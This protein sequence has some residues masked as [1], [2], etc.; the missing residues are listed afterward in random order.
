MEL[1]R[2]TKAES[3]HSSSSQEG[4]DKQHSSF[5]KQG[6]NSVWVVEQEKER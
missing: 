2:M 1:W 6:V 4:L 3:S 5:K